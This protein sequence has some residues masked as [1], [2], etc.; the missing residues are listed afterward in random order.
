MRFIF[1]THYAQ[2]IRLAKHGGQ[3]FWYALLMRG[4]ARRAVGASATTGC[5]A[6]LR[7]DLLHRRA[8]PDAAGRLHRAVLDRP[9]GLPRR[10]RVHAGVFL[11]EPGRAVPARDGRA[12]AL[13]AAVG[14]VVGLPALRVKG[15]Y[16]GIA[17][18]A[19]GFIVEEVFARWESVT[20]GNAGMQRARRR[21]VRLRARLGRR[22]LLR[23][24]RAVACSCTLGVLN[25]LR[26]PHRP[27]LRRDP[28]FGD[29]GAEHGHPPRALQDAV[30]RDLGRA[31]RPRRR[32]VRAQAAV[33]LARPVRHRCSRS[34][35]C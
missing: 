29:L 13:S 6:D 31:R 21:A 2:D 25:L 7:P 27:R 23:V 22:L 10:R 35:C 15:I 12:A 20:G 33:H 32:A 4:A 18:L 5:A 11:L 9:R 30:L 34:T 14:V 8:R 1:K 3:V 28:R 26:S 24:P 17:T 16:L 19:F